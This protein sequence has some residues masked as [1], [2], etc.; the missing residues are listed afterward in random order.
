MNDDD[1]EEDDDNEG[2]DG[3]EGDSLRLY[4]SSQFM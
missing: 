3:N 2:D 1:N 4:S